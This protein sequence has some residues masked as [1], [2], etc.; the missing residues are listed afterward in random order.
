QRLDE[1]LIDLE[2]RLAPGEHDE[3]R[4][5]AGPRGI[6]R[7]RERGGRC[8]FAGV[9][10]DEV[11]IAESADRARAILLAARPEVAACKAAKHRRAAGIH[12]FALQRI[13]DLLYGVHR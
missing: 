10:A 4:A 9:G 12:A 13:E 8:E 3:L 2:R 5:A 1:R 6:D 7:R 11:G